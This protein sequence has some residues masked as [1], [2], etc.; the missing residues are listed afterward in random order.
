MGFIGSVFVTD[1]SLNFFFKICK[2]GVN[3]TFEFKLN[4]CKEID[5][6]ECSTIHSVKNIVKSRSKIS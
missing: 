1:L 5:S 6:K 4:I 3:F 2:F